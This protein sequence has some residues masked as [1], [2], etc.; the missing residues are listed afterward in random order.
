MFRIFLKQDSIPARIN[1]EK[2]IAIQDF[3]ENCEIVI[4]QFKKLIKG[5]FPSP[6][7][8]VKYAQEL[9]KIHQTDFKEFKSAFK[10][11][12]NI[13]VLG[14]SSKKTDKKMDVEENKSRNQEGLDEFNDQIQDN[15]IDETEK[16]EEDKK[17]FKKKIQQMLKELQKK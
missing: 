1:Q 5:I 14:K 10:V 16:E 7:N 15:S 13:N 4:E 17:K 2:K 12:L 3:Y 6:L 9:K 11:D 8:D